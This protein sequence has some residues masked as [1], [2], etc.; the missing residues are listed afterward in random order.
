VE[1][2]ERILNSMNDLVRVVDP[3]GNIVFMNMAMR[4][5]LKRSLGAEDAI[6]RFNS[7]RDY[8]FLNNETEVEID[9]KVYVVR[10]SPLYNDAGGIEFVTEVFHDVSR[11]KGLQNLIVEQNA[12]FEY[13]LRMAKLLQRKLLPNGS[14]N[15]AIEFNYKFEPCTMLGGD[16]IDIYNIIGNPRY[17]GVYIADVSG[18]GV[19]AAVM[20][21]FLRAAIS[22]RLTSPAEAL[23]KLYREFRGHNF[24]PELY[25]T[26]F[27]AIFDF[28]NKVLT[29]SNAGHSGIPILFNRNG[30]DAPKLLE[31][32]G[33]PISAWFETVE[34][35]EASV[36]IKPG[37]RLFLYTDGLLDVP[38]SDMERYGQ[39]R[40][41]N[42]L[43]NCPEDHGEALDMILNDVYTFGGYSNSSDQADDLTISLVE[44][45]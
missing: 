24:E 14:P 36:E 41:L 11:L 20:T 21:I 43:I 38:N 6:N 23:K 29:Y 35:R 3:D 32:E 4:G 7:A 28:E 12:K 39:D 8:G 30:I 34:Y 42:V 33:V 5:Y 1:F 22:K 16:F 44:L 2:N 18:H 13:D 40:A 10:S 17:L 45:L 37:D 31:L 25:I 19:T 26:V 15:P 9:G 27:Y